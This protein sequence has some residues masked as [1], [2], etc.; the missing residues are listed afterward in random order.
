MNGKRKCSVPA[1]AARLTGSGNGC[2]S[3]QSQAARQTGRSSRRGSGAR[4]RGQCIGPSRS[5]IAGIAGFKLLPPLQQA[6]KFGLDCRQPLGQ[7]LR[8]SR[9]FLVKGGVF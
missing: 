5:S 8:L 1:Q 4:R 6:R 3:T 7:S 9:V 2:D